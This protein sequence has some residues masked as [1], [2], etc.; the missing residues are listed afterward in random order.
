MHTKYRRYVWK[1]LTWKLEW[2]GKT[3]VMY[4]Q[5]NTPKVQTTYTH[6]RARTLKTNT[7]D[8]NLRFSLWKHIIIICTVYYINLRLK[9]VV[10]CGYKKQSDF[11]S[12]WHFFDFDSC[13]ALNLTRSV[14]IYFWF[15]YH[16]YAFPR[17]CLYSSCFLP[18]IY[19][20]VCVSVCVL[21]GR[22]SYFIYVTPYSASSF[23][24]YSTLPLSH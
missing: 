22:R 6:R 12:F 19:L 20:Y 3:Q 15:R 8:I 5:S 7:T 18:S 24:I 1:K 23:S 17:Q 14:L 4:R 16:K 21:G 9:M 2:T 13:A 10:C 11:F